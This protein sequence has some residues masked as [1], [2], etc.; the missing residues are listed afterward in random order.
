M[1]RYFLQRILCILPILL[2]ISLVSFLLI[3]LS[4]SDPAEVA[5]RVNEIVPTEEAV[6][7]MRTELGLDKPFFERYIHWLGNCLRFDFGNSYINK[8]PVSGEMLKALPPTLY[9]AGVSLAIILSI[10]ITAGILCAVFEGSMIDKGIRAFIFVGSAMPNF[11]LAL[12]LMWFFAVKLDLFPTSGMGG[13]DSVI[14]PAVT[15]SFSYVSTYTRL[16]RNSMVQNKTENY[17]LYTRVR[18]LKESTVIKHIFKNSLQSS[19]T[20][21]GMSIPKL[22]AGTVIVENIFAWPGIGRLC[23]TAIFNR[24]YPII[25]AYVIM[26]AVLFVV[27]NLLVDLLSASL[28]PRVR[29]EV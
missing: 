18:G 16:L 21:L 13:F 15:L 17:V 7:S 26:M 1:K 29:R 20:A 23:V 22:I 5:L 3:N 12:L 19:I 25:Q 8:K 9:L 2:G 27:C 24:D 14:L 28:D 10:S 11:W 4:P 6:A